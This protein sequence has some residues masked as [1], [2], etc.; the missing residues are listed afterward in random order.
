M[1]SPRVPPRQP[2]VAGDT[3]LT[4]NAVR[5]VEVVSYGPRSR[6]FQRGVHHIMSTERLPVVFLPHGGGPWPFVELGFGDKAET[7]AL[8]TYLRSIRQVPKVAPRALLVV[9]AH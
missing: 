6:G 7:A 8:A 3:P 4:P 1:L 5:Y 9:S 2:S